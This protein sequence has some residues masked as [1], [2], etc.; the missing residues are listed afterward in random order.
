MN[1]EGENFNLENQPLQFGSLPQQTSDSS[2]ITNLNEIQNQ[3][4]Q[5]QATQKNDGINK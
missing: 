5:Q 3:I 4:T 2:T 1:L